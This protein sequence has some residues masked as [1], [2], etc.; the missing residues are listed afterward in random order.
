[1][2]REPAVHYNPDDATMPRFVGL[3]RCGRSL[4]SVKKHSEN[5]D[6]ATCGLC[7]LGIRVDKGMGA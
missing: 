7:K 2:P 6:H 4:D 5:P 1:M 3:T